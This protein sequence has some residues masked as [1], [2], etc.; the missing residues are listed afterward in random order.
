MSNLSALAAT[1]FR[2]PHDL[3]ATPDLETAATEF[4][5]YLLGEFL[6]LSEA[7]SLHEGP[8]DGGNA[9]K[10]MR[11]MFHQEIARIVAESGGL[12][13]ARML[14]EDL[15]DDPAG[16]EEPAVTDPEESR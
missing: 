11:S 6:R 9:G 10:M 14:R 16:A 1:T 5:S 8:M 2:S 13:V 7:S 12:G 15:G 3:P 4:E